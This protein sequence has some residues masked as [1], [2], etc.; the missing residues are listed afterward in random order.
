[1]LCLLF[2]MAVTAGLG[3]WGLL[4][5]E[6]TAQNLQLQ[7]LECAAAQVKKL[8]DLQ[9]KIE[10]LNGEI[11]VARGAVIL[12]STLR[13]E[14]QPA[15]RQVVSGLAFL[16]EVQLQGYTLQ[17]KLWRLSHE[18]KDLPLR[19]SSQ[20]ELEPEWSRPPPDEW[21]ERPLENQRQ[22]TPEFYLML[23]SVRL[24]IK[25]RALAKVTR[26]LTAQEDSNPW[27]AAWLPR[28]RRLP[29]RAIFN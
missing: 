21:G 8:R 10:E 18:C 7:L 9:N 1:M 28:N 5:L 11:E 26:S 13:P 20:R 29:E 23:Q 19:T 16:Q 15:L 25:R 2:A 3:F 22:T 12:A 6:G 27:T 14:L 4:R 17:S 24:G